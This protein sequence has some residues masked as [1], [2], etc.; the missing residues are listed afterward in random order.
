MTAGYYG[1]S[2]EWVSFARTGL[3]YNQGN[4]RGVA[5]VDDEND[6]NDGLPIVGEF[7][8]TVTDDFFWTAQSG[9]EHA[10][11]PRQPL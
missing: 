3:S 11:F 9:S 10:W 4:Y 1:G 7:G 8:D 6:P 5:E 2:L